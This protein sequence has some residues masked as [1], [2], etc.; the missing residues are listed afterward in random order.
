MHKLEERMKNNCEELVRNKSKHWCVDCPAMVFEK[1]R[2]LAY[3]RTIRI[4]WR[5]TS[6]INSQHNRKYR[7]LLLMYKKIHDLTAGSP[8][9]KKYIA[10][11][12][13]KFNI[14]Y[15]TT[16]TLEA[17]SFQQLTVRTNNRDCRQILTTLGQVTCGQG[18]WQVSNGNRHSPYTTDEHLLELIY[19]ISIKWILKEQVCSLIQQEDENPTTTTL[20]KSVFTQITRLVSSSLQYTCYAI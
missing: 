20:N 18:T 8:P 14:D 5:R 15:A 13:D 3:L 10:I 1:D 16:C 6:R 11:L 19:C 2:M 9:I 17:T 7:E 12:N 4:T